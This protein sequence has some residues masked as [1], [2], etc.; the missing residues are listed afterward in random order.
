MH[1]TQTPANNVK[2][3]LSNQTDRQKR[4]DHHIE[5]STTRKRERSPH[6]YTLSPSKRTRGDG[7]I[8]TIQSEPQEFQS[9]HASFRDLLIKDNQA[10]FDRTQFIP[11]L[12]DMSN[13]LLFCRP[14]RF[15][16]SLTISMLQHF[17]G[18]QNADEHQTFYQVS[19]PLDYLDIVNLLLFNHFSTSMCKMI[20][21]ETTKQEKNTSPD[22]TSS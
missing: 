3:R 13:A 15:G 2:G 20:S 1:V 17:H 14:R 18:L 10:Y 4:D 9:G 22:N 19:D 21:T 8:L 11:V 6:A 7:N 16:K 12:E 5:G